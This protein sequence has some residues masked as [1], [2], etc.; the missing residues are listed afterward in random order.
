MM[1]DHLSAFFITPGRGAALT[2]RSHLL[3][4]GRTLAVVRTEIRNAGG[5]RVL[6]AISN[7]A[8]RRHD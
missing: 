2:I 7:H 6:E 1:L 3:H 5:E 4:A 8:A